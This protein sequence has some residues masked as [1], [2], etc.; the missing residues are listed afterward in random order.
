MRNLVRLAAATALS[1]PVLIGAAGL[2]S[3]ESAG[4]FG[5]DLGVGP[6]GLYTNHTEAVAHDGEVGY[7]NEHLYAGDLGFHY[8][9]TSSWADDDDYDDDDD[10]GYD[11][12]GHEAGHAEHS[13]SIHPAGFFHTHSHGAFSETD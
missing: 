9:E 7:Y 13:L 12:D 1:L 4:Y 10:H 5:E 6:L 3:A 11:D 8:H 2:A